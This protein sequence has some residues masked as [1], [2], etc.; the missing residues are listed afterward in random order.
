MDEPGRCYACGTIL[1]PAMYKT[2]ADALNQNLSS[3]EALHAVQGLNKDCFGC[4]RMMLSHIP[5]VEN[6]M[7]L[8]ARKRPA[9]FQ[10]SLAEFFLLP[11]IIVVKQE[12]KEETKHPKRTCQS[13]SRKR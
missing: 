9:S 2:Y 3:R 7:Y 12:K 5:L 10:A 6:Q 13:K 8:S 1:Y 11:D 4:N